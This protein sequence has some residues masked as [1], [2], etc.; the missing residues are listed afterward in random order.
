MKCKDCK[1]WKNV[2]MEGWGSC[3]LA[4]TAEEELYTS[5]KLLTKAEFYCK[6]FYP[7]TDLLNP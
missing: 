4:M 2:E 1:H 3:N 7:K 6:L 5:C